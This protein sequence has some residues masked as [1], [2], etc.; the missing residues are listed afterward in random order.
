MTARGGADPAGVSLS[1]LAQASDDFLLV[2][3][4][5]RVYAQAEQMDEDHWWAACYALTAF[6]EAN[7]VGPDA[8]ADA[9]RYCWT[10]T[11]AWLMIARARQLPVHD[12]APFEFEKPLEGR[13]PSWLQ[14]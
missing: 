13:G 5:G 8:F 10:L 3:Q 6:E 2:D 4:H 12:P 9:R 11:C 7:F 1:W 14:D